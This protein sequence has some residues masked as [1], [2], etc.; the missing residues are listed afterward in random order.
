MERAVTPKQL[1][2]WLLLPIAV[3][4]TAPEHAEPVR[5]SGDGGYSSQSGNVNRMGVS[6]K[7]AHEMAPSQVLVRF[8]EGTDPSAIEG[9]QGEAGVRILKA[10]SGNTLFLMKIM[11]GSSV[12]DAV[13][14]L[15]A[16]PEILYAE[17]NYGRRL[18]DD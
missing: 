17:P 8:R 16:Y 12:E 18:K 13:Q 5:S 15:K 7:P 14:R 11:D 6:D 10:V 4:C 3:A 9:I 1:F 2:Y